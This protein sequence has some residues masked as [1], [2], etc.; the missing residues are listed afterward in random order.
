MLQND[1]ILKREDYKNIYFDK[2]RKIERVEIPVTW[3]KTPKKLTC[4]IVEPRIVNTLHGVLNNVAAIYGNSDVG[5]TIFH[6]NHNKNYILNIIKNWKSVNLIN[7]N[8][9][10]LKIE[11]YS[12]LLTQ[13]SFYKNFT[14][15]HILIFQWDSYIF[16]KIPDYYYDF[17]FV[18]ARW[19]NNIGNNCGNGGISLRNR[20]AMIKHST[21]NGVT[22]PEDFYFA[23]RDLKTC[24]NVASHTLFSCEGIFTA[25][26]CCCHKPF[27]SM[28][29]YT[30]QNEYITFLNKIK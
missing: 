17:D 1:K 9:D 8:V 21:I 30:M 24:D 6:G 12:Q 28:S 19:Q 4:C 29:D 22:S 15:S 10:N 16:K 3:N 20:A 25:D 26:P 13:K 11:E 23:K 27:A 7:M 2:L 14:S 5:L 18:G